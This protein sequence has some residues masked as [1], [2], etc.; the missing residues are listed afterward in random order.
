VRGAR[1]HHHRLNYRLCRLVGRRGRWDRAGRAGPRRRLEHRDRARDLAA[2]LDLDLAEIGGPEFA[3]SG[4]AGTLDMVA[5]LEWVRDNVER[6][7]GDPGAVTI[8]GESAGA[9]SVDNLV[10]SFPKNA[11][12]RA[13]IEQSGQGTFRAR[14]A[15]PYASWNALAAAVGCNSSASALKCMRALPASTLKNSSEHL[16]LAFGPRVD[17]YTFI[18]N[19]TEAR[20]SGNIAKVPVMAGTN[21]DEGS[22]FTYGDTNLTA[23]LTSALPTAPQSYLGEITS[24]YPIGS[25]GI[26]NVS[27][28]IAKIY[29]EFSFQCTQARQLRDNK[30]AGIPTWRYFYNGSIPGIALF[31]GSGVYHASEISLVFG[32][33]RFNPSHTPFEQKLSNYMMGAWAGFAKHPMQG[34]GWAQLPM[35]ANLGTNGTVEKSVPSAT[36]DT[37]CALFD[38]IY[39]L[40]Q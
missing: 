40:L 36:I 9:L 35:V 27:Q 23:Y 26:A 20:M 31:P 24:A 15:D 6:F 18:S 28:Q 14:V 38:P 22:L 21:A 16:A 17:N 8:F 39:D 4:I 13:A 12:F 25:P 7:G 32:T 19:R 30:A 3:A 5:A 1:A 10:T 33:Y 37:R 11:P 34:P 29:T 2:T